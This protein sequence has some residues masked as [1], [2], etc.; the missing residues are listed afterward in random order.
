VKV[1]WSRTRTELPLF[2]LRSISLDK[3]DTTRAT[4]SSGAMLGT[5]RPSK[6]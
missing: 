2:S 3:H 1:L 5:L 6:N 4:Q